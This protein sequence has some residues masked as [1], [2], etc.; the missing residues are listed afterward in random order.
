MRDLIQLKG[1][2]RPL[3]EETSKLTLER[4]RSGVGHKEMK[5]VSANRTATCKPVR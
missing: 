3:W 4:G 2:G 5:T 1:Y